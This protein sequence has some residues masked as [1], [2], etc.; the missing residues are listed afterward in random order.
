MPLPLPLGHPFGSR[1]DSSSTPTVTFQQ[2]GQPYL[3]KIKVVSD[4]HKVQLLVYDGTPVM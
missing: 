3:S 2:F 4:P 1:F